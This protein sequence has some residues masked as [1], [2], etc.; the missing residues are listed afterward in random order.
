MLGVPRDVIY[1]DYRMSEQERRP[2]WELPKITP[3]MAAKKKSDADDGGKRPI[4]DRHQA[5]KS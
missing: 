5:M 3:A 1:A 2:E 4:D